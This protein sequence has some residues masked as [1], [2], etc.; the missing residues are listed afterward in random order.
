MLGLYSFLLGLGLAALAPL[1][2]LRNSPDGRYTRFLSE[3]FGQLAPLGGSQGAIWVHA[4]SVGEALA[5]ERLIAQLQW[6]FPERPV[7]LSVTTAAGR[8]VAQGRIAAER[9]FYFPLDFR[10]AARRALRAL[11]P[12][13]IVIAETEIWPNFLCEAALAQ[14][15][16]MFL[17]GRISG[18]SYARYRLI[19]RFLAPVLAGVHTFLMQ[20]AT[21]A[22]RVVELGAPAA[23]V[24]VGGNVKFDLVP[25]DQPRFVSLLRTGS[26]RA[27]IEQLIVAGSTMEG[28]ESELLAAF[29][30]VS[31]PARML[32]LAPRHPQR[33]E[34]VAGL[35]A[36]SGLP[37]RRRTALGPEE[38]AAMP[39]GGVLLLDSLGELASAY[40]TATVAFVGGSLVPHGGH[41][42]L[43]PAY[44]GVPVT[45]GRHM[46]NFRSI[47]EQFLAAQAAHAVA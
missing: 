15:P 36:A 28:E 31:S 24:R 10:F 18:R 46:E 17:N 25:P 38:T 6:R 20:T 13:L 23:Q 14:V 5:M 35:L 47:A 45:F 29:R 1:L 30:A 7:V 19:R 16:V 8:R 21:D 43:E 40:S 22:E 4:V 9:V 39:A 37:W 34:T 44:W 12:V 11:R 33:F 41:N 2:W 42:L 27:N 3:R 32:V 26:R